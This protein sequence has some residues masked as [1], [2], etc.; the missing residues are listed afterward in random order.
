MSV[1]AVPVKGSP[2][3]YFKSTERT[4]PRYRCVSY[5]GPHETLRK[6]DLEDSERPSKGQQPKI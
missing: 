2:S 3:F 4:F 5:T 1:R 6:D